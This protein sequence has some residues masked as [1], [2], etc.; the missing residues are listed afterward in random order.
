[1]TEEKPMIELNCAECGTPFEIPL[2]MYKSKRKY[3]QKNFFHTRTCAGR[4]SKRRE[5][6]E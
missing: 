4:F 6:S 1:M 5:A 2:G 3:G